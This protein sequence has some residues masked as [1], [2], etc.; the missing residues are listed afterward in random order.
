M[1]RRRGGSIRHHERSRRARRC[2]EDGVSYVWRSS[3][4]RLVIA[5]TREKS[6]CGVGA[7]GMVLATDPQTGETSAREV[8][9]VERRSGE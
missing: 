9:R 3:E 4:H 8:R 6:T 2:G 5:D 1:A 7:S